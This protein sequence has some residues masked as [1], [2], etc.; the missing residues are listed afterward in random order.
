MDAPVVIVGGGPVGLA[1]ALLLARWGVPTVICEAAEARG[2]VGSRSICTQR[3]VLDILHRV[4]CGEVLA[5]E[6]VTWTH[7]RT[8]YRHRELF[9]ITFPA[10]GDA[11]FPPFVNIPQW[12]VEEVLEAAV[13]AE[14]LCDLRYGTAVQGLTQDDEGVT[15]HTGQCDIRA[16][17]VIGADGHHSTVREALGLSFDGESFADRFLI[18]DIRAALPFGPQR[19]FH[20][21]PEWN[22]GRQVLL[23]PQPGSV[24]RIDWQVPAD[25]DLDEAR[26]SGEV[27]ARIRRITGDV[28]Y[29]IVWLSAYRFAQRSAP[30]YVRGRVLLAGDAAHVMTP[31]GARGLNSGIADA[32]NAAWKI[33]LLRR[34]LAGPSLLDSY[35]AERHAAAVENLA[36]TGRTMRFLVPGDDAARA[37]RRDVLERALHDPA[38]RAEVDSGKLYEPFV[39][40]GSPLTTGWGFPPEGR[41]VP[42]A[43][44]PDAAVPGGRLRE[45]FGTGF[46]VI[47]AGREPPV[48]RTAV[49][50]SRLRLDAEALEPAAGRVWIVRP[51]GHL[52]GVLDD[53]DE[54]AVAAVLERA[55]GFPAN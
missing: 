11:G 18:A 52:A 47:A 33:A 13:A 46:T 36:I 29:T 1:A 2:R 8:Y 35:H 39:Y 30:S 54:S 7:G 23:H 9:R 42:G 6:G 37:H 4:G 51:D 41:V 44:C 40:V 26:A 27:D 12:R 25:F 24:W 21:D 3:D 5:S 53:A 17:H 31:F 49:R 50:V 10:T 32:E 48:P 28:P 20:F 19:R 22:P 15:V 34:G 38:A 16:T 14:P 43:L 55:L 45:R